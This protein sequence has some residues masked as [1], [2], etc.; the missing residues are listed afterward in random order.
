MKH[1]FKPR[2]RYW[3][4]FNGFELRL[5]G[6][7]VMACHHQGACDSDVASYA[8]R[9]ERPASCTPNAL[10]LELR[11]YGAWDDAELADDAAN[12]Q[13]IIWL[14]AGMIQDDEKPDSSRPVGKIE[15]YTGPAT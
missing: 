11:E 7:A 12:W 13:R 15:L 14:A 9:V 2:A 6:A 1:T 4:S 3:A 5:S 8:P 10:R